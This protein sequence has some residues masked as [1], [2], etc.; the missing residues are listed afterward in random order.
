MHNFFSGSR[1]VRGMGR[2]LKRTRRRAKRR[3][4]MRSLGI[5]SA[6]RVEILEQR[7]L[8][9]ADF[10]AIVETNG[11]FADIKLTSQ[12]GNFKVNYDRDSDA[13]EISS[14]QDAPFVVSV[15]VE[16]EMLNVV[17][18][19]SQT[20]THRVLLRSED[21]GGGPDGE[22][23]LVTSPSPSQIEIP[24]HTLV[25]STV[26]SEI[27]LKT[28]DL[29]TKLLDDVTFFVLDPSPERAVLD[30]QVGG[31]NV[32]QNL[33]P[34]SVFI[35]PDQDVVIGAVGDALGLTEA[36]QRNLSDQLRVTGDQLFGTW[37]AIANVQV[38]DGENS[39]EAVE[40]VDA[41]TQVR[42]DI[43][44]EHELFGQTEVSLDFKEPGIDSAERLI[45][46]QQNTIS[47]L[48]T[49]R[50]LGRFE[51][52]LSARVEDG[53]FQVFDTFVLTV[54]EPEV[55][56][57][58]G[59]YQSLNGVFA[60]DS[61]DISYTGAFDTGNDLP[62]IQV[63]AIHG[64]ASELRLPENTNLVLSA[65]AAPL[66]NDD[67]TRQVRAS[68]PFTVKEGGFF[69]FDLEQLLRDKS[70][71]LRPRLLL[72]DLTF[73]LQSESGQAIDILRLTPER[74]SEIVE[75]GT[76][77]L[78]VKFPV[79]LDVDLKLNKDSFEIGRNVRTDVDVL[80]DNLI[81]VM[82]NEAPGE[83]F[84]VSVDF[85]DGS[86]PNRLQLDS[87][88]QI[89][90]GTLTRGIF[91]FPTEHLMHDFG[92]RSNLP[93]STADR[94]LDHAYSDPGEFKITATVTLPSGRVASD[95][96]TV[97][98]HDFPAFSINSLGLTPE[99]QVFSRN[100]QREIV[101]A[102]TVPKLSLN[103][104]S[105]GVFQDSVVTAEIEIRGQ[106]QKININ[107]TNSES[108]FDQLNLFDFIDP[109]GSLEERTTRVK[110]T[111]RDEA[112]DFEHESLHDI[113]V[114]VPELIIHGF[115][116]GWDITRSLPANTLSVVRVRGVPI[117]ITPKP[118]TGQEPQTIVVND[119]IFNP[120]E[121][122]GTGG[123]LQMAVR[124]HFGTPGLPNHIQF[125]NGLDRQSNREITVE[126]FQTEEVIFNSATQAE[127][128]S[129]LGSR[130]DI[131]KTNPFELSQPKIVGLEQAFRPGSTFVE[132]ELLRDVFGA[133][134][135]SNAPLNMEVTVDFGDG[136]DVQRFQID[137]RG[138]PTL[139]HRISNNPSF[140][141]G[142]DRASVVLKVDLIVEGEVVDTVEVPYS[143]RNLNPT[144]STSRTVNILPLHP[145]VET[146]VDVFVLFD[147]G[148]TAAFWAN[149]FAKQS[150]FPVI[151]Q[152]HDAG[153][154]DQ[155]DAQIRNAG[156]PVE[157][158]E[159]FMRFGVTFAPDDIR[160]LGR[161]LSSFQETL[162]PISV[163][164][165]VTD[166]DLA[167]TT[168][169]IRLST[170]IS[171]VRITADGRPTV[172]QQVATTGR[173]LGSSEVPLP[174]QSS[175][176]VG[177]SIEEFTFTLQGRAR[178][179]ANEATSQEPFE[180]TID[181]GDGREIE[182]VRDDS[183][184]L[185]RAFRVRPNA[186]FEVERVSYNEVTGKIDLV[187]VATQE[188]FVQ[189]PRVG[190]YRVTATTPIDVLDSDDAYGE[191]I[192][193]ILPD[194]V[195]LVTGEGSLAGTMHLGS[196]PEGVN[197]VNG[198][199]YSVQL[200]VAEDFEVLHSQTFQNAFA[201]EIP[202]RRILVGAFESGT[203]LD[204]IIEVPSF[205]NSSGIVVGE[206][207]EIFHRFIPEPKADI[208]S[209]GIQVTGTLAQNSPLN[210]SLTLGEETL[211]D[212]NSANDDDPFEM[213]VELGDGSSLRLV[214]NGATPAGQFD[215]SGSDGTLTARVP[216]NA[217]AGAVSLSRVSDN[218]P[219]VVYEDF[220][221][222]VIQAASECGVGSTRVVIENVI[223]TVTGQRFQLLPDSLEF[224]ADVVM[225]SGG[226]V[227][228]DQGD[229]FSEVNVAANSQPQRVRVVIENPDVDIREV[230][231]TT[232]EDEPN[233]PT[234]KEIFDV[235][236]SG[237][238][239]VEVG[240]EFIHDIG[241]KGTLHFDI[242]AL[243]NRLFAEADSSETGRAE[244][245]FSIDLGDG[246]PAIDVTVVNNNGVTEATIAN[247][248]IAVVP[249][250]AERLKISL[251]V[252]LQAFATT[253]TLSN[254]DDDIRGQVEINILTSLDEALE[255]L[256]AVFERES[257]EVTLIGQRRS[258]AQAINIDVINKGQS[259][260]QID[261]PAGEANFLFP[262]VN[263]QPGDTL[264]LE[265]DGFQ[266]ALITVGEANLSAC[267]DHPFFRIL[268]YGGNVEVALNT[269][270][271]V[272][273]GDAANN[274]ISIFTNQQ[275]VF[276]QGIFGTLINGSLDPFLIAGASSIDKLNIVSMGE[277]DDQVCVNTVRVEGQSDITSTPG[278]DV[279]LMTDV[280]VGGDST[281][282]LGADDDVLA[283]QR[284]AIEGRSRIEAGDGDD[285]IMAAD[286]VDEIHAGEGDDFIDGGLSG[287][288]L[289]GAQ[290]DD[291]LVS[292]S[293]LDQVDGGPDEDV[294][295]LTGRYEARLASEPLIPLSD[296]VV[297]ED[298]TELKVSFERNFDVASDEV[299]V[300]EATE[301]VGRFTTIP[302]S[303]EHLGQGYF[304][305]AFD[306]SDETVRVEAQRVVVSVFQ[307]GAGDA[308]GDGIFNSADF[309]AAFSAGTYEAGIDADWTSGDWNHDGRFDSTDLILAFQLG[310]YVITG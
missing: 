89:D 53:P 211:E 46:D 247:E 294:V 42:F 25:E 84:E 179:R 22:S 8:L 125:V 92:V 85:G 147:D 172:Q 136:S 295:R 88:F 242:T 217:E 39:P 223:P 300:L 210:V 107:E 293:S 99:P 61:L 135:V 249:E 277:G 222:F 227:R 200:N 282:R 48:H 64:R 228:L 6:A 187:D 71:D 21:L 119:F 192:V 248:P 263:A 80:I 83:R 18:G 299:T 239:I 278:N 190:R 304:A 90:R 251:P 224:S 120:S 10:D 163:G 289:L 204:V 116:S 191:L 253:V 290:G 151:F 104:R 5:G 275:G 38:A 203:P 167:T 215:V 173:A 185:S 218:Q 256:V 220:G 50:E 234:F 267:E 206:A 11:E 144:I 1:L 122:D 160:Q 159:N 237:Q 182:L 123:F 19:A 16:I 212:A 112:G 59:E 245:T 115:T 58:S 213:T 72:G 302:Q 121:L 82:A 238:D 170:S 100:E 56:S 155:L 246:Q 286:T 157:V 154:A 140:A 262:I 184:D 101:V 196:L 2:Q 201:D 260:G 176:T 94:L 134:R 175:H 33:V 41:N 141:E 113:T 91:D 162:L 281:I 76:S 47:I 198:E 93:S 164:L 287:D 276:V 236:P 31:A 199:D 231:V 193:D 168:S 109:E 152:V 226:R 229:R 244:D 202:L 150:D 86:A 241:R 74:L 35:H 36:S 306:G 14:T 183:E 130:I 271:L 62:E 7:R 298:D 284:V 205:V 17:T 273:N 292:D 103:L 63:G 97:K 40:F 60:L 209:I 301:I 283:M 133:T 9:A 87:R 28:T 57:V 188:P 296:R 171:P 285:L 67:G 305:N 128:L 129:K 156:E 13:L 274:G 165:E 117:A 29:R 24:G 43:L 291:V 270:E 149:E 54:T 232:Q 194:F 310:T 225:P 252:S 79:A 169:T 178:Q 127:F 102:K 303:G 266:P 69:S 265:A 197:Y 257:G 181:L 132:G 49:F 3:N 139:D 177:E 308:T 70:E 272:I 258:T 27:R 44:V 297:I 208:E 138:L 114:D 189:F 77:P 51:V 250:G 307:A 166:D 30:A 243:A 186:F 153:D 110:L 66:G 4:S 26:G 221:A 81:E 148:S 95:S 78:N 34:Q 98:V 20:V 142:E 279:V 288:I 55:D 268:P 143:I 207:A 131:H 216:Y 219:L 255:S 23:V 118:E 65:T 214:R 309:I 124:H 259:Q 137:S 12:G 52:T 146:V 269:G 161:F 145:L 254:T 174:T 32:R 68:L 280:A 96:R 264:R 111:I 230:S 37:V 108:L 240:V 75:R 158:A 45:P 106:R 261:I 180:L 235:E 126:L 73:I 15:P 233:S 105:L 195:T